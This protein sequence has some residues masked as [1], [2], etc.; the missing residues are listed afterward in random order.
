MNKFVCNVCGY[1]YETDE[2]ELPD[3]FVCPVCGA[4]KEDFTKM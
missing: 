1:V 3:N 4:G 2:N